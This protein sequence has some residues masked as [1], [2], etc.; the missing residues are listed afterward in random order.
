MQLLRLY[1]ELHSGKWRY[2]YYNKKGRYNNTIH[3]SA[4][5]NTTIQNKP[6]L[7]YVPIIKSTDEIEV[8]KLLFNNDFYNDALNN[9]F[10][11]PVISP[12]VELLNKAK[13]GEITPEEAT[14]QI[15]RFRNLDL[16]KDFR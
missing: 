2:C 8:E 4:S 11:R 3:I 16:R 10:N 6:D 9:T 1:G 14:Q 15:D 13:N 12:V 5:S 7:Y